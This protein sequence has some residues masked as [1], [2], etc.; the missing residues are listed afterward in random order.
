MRRYW[1][2]LFFRGRRK[3]ALDGGAILSWV[4]NSTPFLL[5]RARE[6]GWSPKENTP[7]GRSGSP[8]WTPPNGQE[9]NGFFPWIPFSLPS[10]KERFRHR[11]SLRGR[12]AYSTC[13]KRGE[14]NG[15]DAS[16]PWPLGRGSR[17][18]RTGTPPPGVLSLTGRGRF[19]PTWER[20][21]GGFPHQ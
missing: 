6:T 18:R 14:S 13:A 20:N 19:F 1:S 7:E 2:W 10:K 17:G 3:R 4:R 5:R 21:G 11:M 16:P 8:L 15:G 9:K 12:S